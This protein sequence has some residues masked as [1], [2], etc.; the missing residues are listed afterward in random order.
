MLNNEKLVNTV[1]YRHTMKLYAAVKN[2]VFCLRY[3]KL[4]RILTPHLQD[5]LKNLENMQIHNFSWTHEGAEFTRWPLTG[6]LRTNKWAPAKWGGTQARASPGRALLCTGRENSAKIVTGE[7]TESLVTTDIGTFVSARADFSSDLSGHS[8][9]LAKSR[10]SIFSG[11]DVGEG[12]IGWH[13]EGL[14]Q[15][16]S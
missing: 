4:E 13:R 8:Q 7:K 12:N 6:N 1:L 16:R 11:T 3:R 9:R 10:E 15:L 2:N 14:K 5:F